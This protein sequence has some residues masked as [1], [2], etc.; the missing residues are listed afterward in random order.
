MKI[1][2]KVKPVGILRYRMLSRRTSLQHFGH[3]MVTLLQQPGLNGDVLH[4]DVLHGDD[5]DLHGVPYHP[6][7]SPCVQ[8]MHGVHN[9]P[10]HVAKKA[11]YPWNRKYSFNFHVQ[12]LRACNSI[13]CL[14]YR[15]LFLLY[16]FLLDQ[17]TF[18]FN[19]IL[20]KFGK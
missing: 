17:R 19:K 2:H 3:K 9:C 15:I 16:R 12:S 5:H 7:N 20:D 8:T 4:G 1:Y 14:N 18:F 6:R 11:F 10:P 13:K